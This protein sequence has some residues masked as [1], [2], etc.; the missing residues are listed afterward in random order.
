[1]PLWGG[2]GGVELKKAETQFLGQG[3]RQERGKPQKNVGRGPKGGDFKK[4]KPTP[5][6]WG[7]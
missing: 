6:N 2:G 4:G 7:N 1:M 3:D 5:E